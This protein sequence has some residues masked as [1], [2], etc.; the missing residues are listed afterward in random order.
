MIR[1]SWFQ[2]LIIVIEEAIEELLIAIITA[3]T[4]KVGIAL[5]FYNR[6]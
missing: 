5:I 1:V 2:T 6:L 3:V 4:T